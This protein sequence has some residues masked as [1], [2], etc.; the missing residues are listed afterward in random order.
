MPAIPLPQSQFSTLRAQPAPFVNS[1]ILRNLRPDDSWFDYALWLENRERS[2]VII[3]KPLP[4]IETLKTFA[5]LGFVPTI[6]TVPVARQPLPRKGMARS[7]P[8]FI[9]SRRR[10][11]GRF[12]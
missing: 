11:R 4:T 12:G 10:R 7:R 5:P 9:S 2:N 3:H 8:I 6:N 1:S